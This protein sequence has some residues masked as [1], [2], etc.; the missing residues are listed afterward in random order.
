VVIDN[1]LFGVPSVSKDGIES[2]VVY[3][4]EIGAFGE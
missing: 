1:Y 2:P 3:Q 4:C